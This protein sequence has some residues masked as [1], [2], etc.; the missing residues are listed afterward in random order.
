MFSLILGNV[1]EENKVQI[2]DM[3]QYKEFHA[4]SVTKS[5]QPLNDKRKWI[6]SIYKINFDRCEI[7]ESICSNLNHIFVDC[8]NK[9]IVFDES[10]T[11]IWTK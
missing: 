3:H 11:D 10:Y 6:L 4:A 7:P 5:L 8:G 2:N 9:A 1:E